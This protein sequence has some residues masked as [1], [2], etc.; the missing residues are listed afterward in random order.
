MGSCSCNPQGRDKASISC[1]SSGSSWPIETGPTTQKAGD[2]GTSL[3][4][5][6]V[7]LLSVMA[8]TAISK[9]VIS[10][11]NYTNLSVKDL[12]NRIYQHTC[13]QPKH[14]ILSF[15]LLACFFILENKLQTRRSEG[16]TGCVVLVRGTNKNSY[17]HSLCFIAPGGRQHATV[18]ASTGKARESAR[19][20]R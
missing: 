16:E 1:L 9:D 5:T 17:T 2:C 6:P 7:Y 18:V 20:E 10:S 14:R 4:L 15:V 19:S 11:P 13:E 8:L 3:P 12:R